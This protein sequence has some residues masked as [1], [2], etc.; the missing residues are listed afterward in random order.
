MLSIVVERTV[1]EVMVE[2]AVMVG[3]L[4]LKALKEAKD[5]G[6]GGRWRA[7]FAECDM[8]AA[9]CE[10]VVSEATSP[11]TKFVTGL[12]VKLLLVEVMTGE[13]GLILW[14]RHFSLEAP[15]IRIS[16]VLAGRIGEGEGNST[17]TGLE[18][19]RFNNCI[20]D[21]IAVEIGGIGYG[22]GED[23]TDEESTGDE[24]EEEEVTKEEEEQEFTVVT[25]T[26]VVVVVD[27]GEGA[28]G[29]LSNMAST[30]L[31]VGVI[32][33]VGEDFDDEES[34]AVVF[35]NIVEAGEGVAE[36]LEVSLM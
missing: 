33:E 35:G 20:E 8:M 7:S 9:W 13:I 10:L 29:S 12:E 16:G 6:R 14:P 2:E 30:A 4:V 5:R 18:L 27:R 36:S 3:V 11:N 19:P 17:A 32:E 31:S 22:V 26:G 25:F 28:G 23:L 24:E 21:T 15:F 1:G 34:P